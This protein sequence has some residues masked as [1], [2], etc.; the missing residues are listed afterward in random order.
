MIVYGLV[1]WKRI[2]AR[3]LNVLNFPLEDCSVFGNFLITLIVY[4]C[5]AAEDAA[6]NRAWLGSH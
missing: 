5:F 2:C 1:G 4:M 6:I 3:I